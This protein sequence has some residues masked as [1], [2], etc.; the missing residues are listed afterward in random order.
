M[1]ILRHLASVYELE[2]NIWENKIIPFEQESIKMVL[3]S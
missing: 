3:Q 2:K 1:M